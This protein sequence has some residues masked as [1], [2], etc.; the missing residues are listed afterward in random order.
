MSPD[1][2][3][4]LILSVCQ[5]SLNLCL[6][7][8]YLVNLALC[9]SLTK[10]FALYLLSPKESVKQ[11]KEWGIIS[12]NLQWSFKKRLSH[13]PNWPRIQ[14]VMQTSLFINQYL[15]IMF[16]IYG[17]YLFYKTVLSQISV[18]CKWLSEQMQTSMEIM[19][20][21]IIYNHS[22]DYLRLSKLIIWQI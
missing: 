19:E 3:S 16:Y 21:Y 13:W 11:G 2:N 9:M 10:G 22:Y 6:L 14:T 17:I 12:R 5:M 4:I 8:G 7:E 20:G 18:S 1:F 15:Y